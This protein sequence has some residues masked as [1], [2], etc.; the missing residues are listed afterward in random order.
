M[1]EHDFWFSGFASKY[2]ESRKHS[3]DSTYE[4]GFPSA[5]IKKQGSESSI[6]RKFFADLKTFSQVF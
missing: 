4:I 2:Y 1:I 5:K 3:R 6:F